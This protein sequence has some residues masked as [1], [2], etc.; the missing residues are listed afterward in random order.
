MIHS[1]GNLSARKLSP[2]LVAKCLGN[3][4]GPGY[5]ATKMTNGDL[6]LELKDK[7]Q[8]KKM[9]DL[10]CIGD[11]AVT[12]S[13]HRTMNTSRGVISEDD[14]LHLSDEELLD[15]FQNQNVIKVERILIRRNNEQI[16]TKHIVLT[17][18]SCELPTTLDAGYIKLRVRPYIPNPRRCCKCQRYGHGSQTCRGKQTCAKCSSNEHTSDACDSSPHCVNCDG[19]HPA[20][21]RTCPKWKIEKEIISLKVKEN[22][23]FREARKRLSY[24]D[25]TSF[26]EVVQRGVA[27]QMPRQS[28]A[29]TNSGPVVTSS[30]P[31][32]AAA[33]AAPPSKAGLQA[34]AQ[35]APK[36]HRIPRAETQVSVPGP[37]PSS[38]SEKAME[39]DG[40]TPASLTPKE[41]RSLE[42][43]KK[44]K[45][46]ITA[47][48]KGSVT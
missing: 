13:A 1:E 31:Q 38:A 30:T 37:R 29:V 25:H 6:L 18:D 11:V 19:S 42:R 10:K 4:I 32:V 41:Q 47:P 17:F 9:N 7:D 21:S 33:I 12:V 48:P 46:P 8:F 24:L 34:S 16:R 39:I 2:F 45:H 26:A 43:N 28:T 35:Q 20:Y 44:G 27:P 36:L 40:R 23:T 5:K 3:T 15:G 14:F 22:V